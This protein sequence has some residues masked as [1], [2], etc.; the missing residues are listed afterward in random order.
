MDENNLVP[1]LIKIAPPITLGLW[2]RLRRFWAFIR[3]KCSKASEPAVSHSFRSSELVNPL[4][5]REFIG[6]LSDS[7]QEIVA[8][9]IEGANRSNRFS[10][11]FGT[12]VRNGNQ[13]VEWRNSET[14]EYFGYRYIATSP[15]G[16]EMLLCHDSGGGSSIFCSIVLLCFENDVTLITEVTGNEKEG[17]KREVVTRKRTLLKIIGSI[18]L[19]DK[20]GGKIEYKNGF[21]IIGPDEGWYRRGKE[22]AN[23]LPVR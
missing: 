1:I 20:Y 5:V 15:S 19:G 7:G 2:R 17:F 8:V 21:L 9:D 16:V 4:I 12:S 3:A 11:G 23:K 6:W 22:F 18:A 13:W 10:G 14:R